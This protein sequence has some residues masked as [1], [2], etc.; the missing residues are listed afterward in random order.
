[1]S[2]LLQDEFGIF[3]SGIMWDG[4]QFKLW[5]STRPNIICFSFK[6]PVL[7]HSMYTWDANS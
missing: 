4:K 2:T 7:V 6:Q 1:M 3:M 5:Q